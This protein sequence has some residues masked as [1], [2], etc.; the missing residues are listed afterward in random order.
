MSAPIAMGLV[1]F[2]K[3]VPQVAAYYRA[4]LCL[5]TVEDETSHVLLQGQGVELVIHAIP[6]GIA[7]QIHI[8]QPPEQREDTALKPTFTVASLEAVRT[9][10][11]ATGGWL[12]PLAKAWQIRGAT[13]LDGCDPE[14]NVVQFKQLGMAP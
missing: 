11:E 8:T 13:V 10:T 9:A 12:K 7:A 1:V 6:K 4:T 14:G 5:N 3:S 2:A